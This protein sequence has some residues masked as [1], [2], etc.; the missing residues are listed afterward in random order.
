[1]Y[2]SVQKPIIGI[3]MAVFRHIEI[4]PWSIVLTV[5]TVATLML[6]CVISMVINKYVPILAGK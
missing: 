4:L 6:A 1:M 2:F 3:F 5:T